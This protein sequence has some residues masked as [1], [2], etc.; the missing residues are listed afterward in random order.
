MQRM[1]IFNDMFSSPFMC[2]FMFI[3]LNPYNNIDF[4]NIFA[5]EGFRG[6]IAPEL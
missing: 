4:V 6:L 5:K 2:S 3:L 1:Y